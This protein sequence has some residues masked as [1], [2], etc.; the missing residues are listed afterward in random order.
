MMQ[1]AAKVSEQS[2]SLPRMIPE[3]QSF[4]VRPPPR[5]EQP[6]PPQISQLAT[7]QMSSAWTPSRPLEH[8]LGVGAG[9]GGDV[10]AGVIGASARNG[11][12][13]KEAGTVRLCCRG[14]KRA[15]IL[16]K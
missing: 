12:K 9:V 2:S 15:L 3:Q 1:G 16:G 13:K 14:R 7:Q 10:G 4:L 6:G 5:S 8:V 11:G